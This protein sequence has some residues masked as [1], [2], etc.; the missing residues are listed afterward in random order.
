MSFPTSATTCSITRDFRCRSSGQASRHFTKYSFW[1]LPMTRI[2]PLQELPA[3]LTNANDG[4]PV[5]V[6]ATLRHG[7][8]PLFC[9]HHPGSP[10]TKPLP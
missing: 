6:V 2:G 7:A 8:M 4:E 3:E 9:G 10:P 5:E 1:S